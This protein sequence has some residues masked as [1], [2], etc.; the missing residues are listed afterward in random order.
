MSCERNPAR[1]NLHAVLYQLDTS[2]GGGQT[3]W[4]AGKCT[5]RQAVSAAELRVKVDAAWAVAMDAG[6]WESLNPEGQLQTMQRFMEARTELLADPTERTLVALDAYLA[7][8]VR[9]VRRAER[10]GSVKKRTVLAITAGL[11]LTLGVFTG[12]TNPSVST[13]AVTAVNT[14]VA[15]TA[16]VKG[17]CVDGSKSVLLRKGAVVKWQAR[18]GQIVSKRLAKKTRACVAVS[19]GSSA[20]SSGSLL[21]VGANGAVT[22]VSLPKRPS[23][24]DIAALGLT[25]HSKVDPNLRIPMPSDAVSAAKLANTVRPVRAYTVTQPHSTGWTLN[26]GETFDGTDTIVMVEWELVGGS[27]VV[28]TNTGYVPFVNGTARVV[29]SLGAADFQNGQMTGVLVGQIAPNYGQAS[30]PASVMADWDV[31]YALDRDGRTG[32]VG[33]NA[34]ASNPQFGSFMDGAVRLDQNFNLLP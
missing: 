12:S 18:S 26:G 7:R 19:A 1:R 16:P 23:V 2:V 33:V 21:S 6:V 20:V 14:G 4:H 11:M 10:V 32:S 24:G 9:E 29:T 15:Y 34:S 3:F 30:L 5:G 25:A 8:H 22:A 13:A 31:P 17:Q 28:E 27:G